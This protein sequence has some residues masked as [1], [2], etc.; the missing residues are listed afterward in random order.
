MRPSAAVVI[1]SVLCLTPAVSLLGCVSDHAALYRGAIEDARFPR[2]SGVAHD[3]LTITPGTPSLRWSD[4]GRSVLVYTWTSQ[5]YYSDPKYVAGFEL[6]L[7]DDTWFTAGTEVADV[8]RRS[9]LEGEALRLRLVQLLGLSPDQQKDAFLAVWIEPTHLFR[10][11]VDRDPTQPTCPIAPPVVVD[12]ETRGWG[13]RPPCPATDPACAEPSDHERWLCANWINTYAHA[14][15]EAGFPW[16]ALG[17]TYDWNPDTP[18]RGP[19][20]FVARKGVRVRF[21]SLTSTDAFC[22]NDQ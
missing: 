4:D 7:Y 21:E 1:A 11:C 15:P 19:T 16:T 3:L 8:C 9:G 2:P 10:P 6:P 14:D 22:S 5:Q 17:Y 13:C 20:E 12:G 18:P